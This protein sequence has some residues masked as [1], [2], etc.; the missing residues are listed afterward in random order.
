MPDTDTDRRSH[1]EEQSGDQGDA[2]S[3]QRVGTGVRDA[4][5]LAGLEGLD[6]GIDQEGSQ[7][8][9]QDVTN[10]GRED[11]QDQGHADAR[12]DRRPSAACSDAPVQCGR[13]DRPAHGLAAEK[14]C[15]KVGHALGSEVAAGIRPRAIRVRGGLGDPGALDDDDRRDGQRT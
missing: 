10:G 14:P 9:E 6:G 5:D 3:H 13:A 8:R 2:E 15:G 12:P 1:G 7:S 4:P 11:H